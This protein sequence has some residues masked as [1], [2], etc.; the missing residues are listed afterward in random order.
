MPYLNE[1]LGKTVREVVVTE[2][3]NNYEI[4]PSKIDQ[5]DVDKNRQLLEAK[6]TQILRN[7]TAKETLDKMPP[8]LRLIAKFVAELAKKYVPD[9]YYTLIGAFIFL[10]FVRDMVWESKQFLI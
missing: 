8:G 4:D 2:R 10:R 1:T 5:E 3:K 7:L 9:Q 6:I